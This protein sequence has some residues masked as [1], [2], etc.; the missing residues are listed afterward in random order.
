MDLYTSIAHVIA[1]VVLAIIVWLIGPRATR[2]HR[3]LETPVPY[4]AH[5]P[6]G[7]FLHDPSFKIPLKTPLVI[8]GPSAALYTSE[9]VAEAQVGT[10]LVGTTP[11]RLTLSTAT[12]L[13]IQQS[14][15]AGCRDF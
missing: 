6:S 13:S 3:D 10:R 9:T 7:G 8:V 11:M 4:R 12:S 14:S 5:L 2:G 1:L 15:T